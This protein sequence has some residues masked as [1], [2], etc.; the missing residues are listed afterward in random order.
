MPAAPP[1]G[2][3]VHA[4]AETGQPADADDLRP[5]GAKAVGE[6]RHVNPL[7]IRLIIGRSR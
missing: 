4:F 2:R 5:A 1:S 6:T 3:Q 7:S